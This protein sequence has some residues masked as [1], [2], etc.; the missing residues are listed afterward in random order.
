MPNIL[1]NNK[2]LIPYVTAAV[3]ILFS[4]VV[5]VSCASRENTQPLYWQKLREDKGW[6]DS[7]N[8]YLD[9]AY[10]EAS[11]IAAFISP[12]SATDLQPALY[13]TY[14]VF[15]ILESIGAEILNQ[16]KIIQ[17]IDSL[18]NQNG[19]YIALT[20]NPYPLTEVN[21]ALTVLI[22]LG[23]EPQSADVTA[24]YILS[25]LYEDG[26]FLTNPGGAITLPEKDTSRRITLGTAAAVYSLKKLG[27]TDKI[28]QATQAVIRAEIDSKLAADTPYP[29]LTESVAW[30]I[31]AAIEVLA[32]IDPL[33]VTEHDR[34]F[35]VFALNGLLDIPEMVEYVYL[36]PARAN[37]LLDIAEITGLSVTDNTLDGIRNK[38][39][40]KVFPQQNHFGG[41]GPETT[42][43]PLMT[44]ENVILSQRL[45]LDYP[46][47]AVLLIEIEKHW[48]GNGWSTF[49][50]N[51]I[52][53][54]SYIFTHY[55]LEIARFS[56][57]DRYDREK[58]SS[59]LR[60]AF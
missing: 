17:Y 19:A 32:N 41:F 26:T 43:E 18:R 29:D 60:G 1:K 37:R 20:T 45:G 58:V 10:V 6:V 23:G 36:F 39:Q 24:D 7:L 34:E 25:C 47:L 35:V 5:P 48:M 40:E 28:P 57:F 16:E 8:Q 15:R 12:S 30:N 38:L 46:D 44:S 42:I 11:D 50:E 54:S 22:G 49:Y 4:L 21:Q 13:S 53:S 56:G 27:Q 33:L 14:S 52:V 3:I 31:L 51:K 9:L 59:Y 2:L 55:A